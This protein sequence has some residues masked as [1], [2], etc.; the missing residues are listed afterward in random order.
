MTAKTRRKILVVDDDRLILST[1]AQG[2]RKLGYEVL[3]ASTAAEALDH[4]RRER[5]DLALVDVRLP[6]V[7]GPTLARRLHEEFS[8]PA[9]FLSAYDD[10]MAVE[11]AA[12]AGGLGYLTKPCNLQSLVPALEVAI[13]RA[14]ELEDLRKR[15]ARL[16]QALEHNREINVAV[17]VLMERFRLSRQAAYDRLRQRARQHRCKVRELAAQ[18]VQLTEAINSFLDTHLGAR[19]PR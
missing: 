17:G 7:D 13:H 4:L 18:L 16:Q 8:V 14:R 6:D 3:E 5:A 19:D 11:A 15:Q 10:Q 12:A 1:L 2:L 9:L